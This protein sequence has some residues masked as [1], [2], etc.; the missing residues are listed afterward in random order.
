M[1]ALDCALALGRTPGLTA[2]R[3]RGALQYL[4]SQQPARTATPAE[5]L[6][7]L[8][9]LP[10]RRLRSLQLS[11]AA[12]GA[13]ALPDAGQLARDRAWALSEGI[14]LLHAL[15][16][17]YPPQLLEIPDAPALLYVQGDAHSLGAAQLAMVGTR[18]PTSI[19]AR[20]ARCFAAYLAQSGLIITS[21][22]ALGIDAASHEGALAAGGRSI[23]VLGRGLDAI[24][25]PEHAT[26]AARIV[27]QGALVSEFPPGTPPR[28]GNFPRRNRLISALSR[29]VLVVE[30]ARRSGSLITARLAAEQ[31]RE[32]FAVPGS[33]HNPM[34]R[35]CHA[36]I[37]SG[38]RLV[39]SAAE[40]LQELRLPQQIS[41]LKQE[42]IE[43]S[44]DPS[45]GA[46]SAAPLD[47]DYKILLDA[48]G[49]EPAGVDLLVERS[50]LTSPSVAS[51]LLILELE[52]HVELQADGRYMRV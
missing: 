9:G 42:V 44:P 40:I 17:R 12:V 35:G 28:R 25:P 48:L 36:L 4:S 50:G 21:G 10:P 45:Y 52:G 14:T 23:A 7:Q 38:A 41:L 32:V 19:G 39:E 24:Y 30:A 8:I 47:N 27:A 22:L 18:R 6:T 26:L 51:M 20:T 16:A 11:E 46:I 2:A 49:H 37:R 1:D 29:G 3:L 43:T 15:D 13:L 34:V 5:G 33:I 31:G